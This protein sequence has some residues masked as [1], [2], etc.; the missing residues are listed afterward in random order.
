M[1]L[2]PKDEDGK[3]R[4]LKFPE[5][6][7]FQ[8]SPKDPCGSFVSHFTSLITVSSSSWWSLFLLLILSTITL[9]RG[10]D[11]RNVQPSQLSQFSCRHSGNDAATTTTTTVLTAATV[12]ATSTPPPLRL[13]RVTA[14]AT[15]ILRMVTM[16]GI[17]AADA[18]E[19]P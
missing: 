11:S 8:W 16:L 15:Q 9:W 12:S 7:T 6:S 5:L 2:R 1:P 19:W 10:R 18:R 4:T 3:K 17:S 13:L 14:L